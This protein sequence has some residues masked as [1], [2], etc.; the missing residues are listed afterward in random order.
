MTLG[1]KSELNFQL[2]NYNNNYSYAKHYDCAKLQNVPI[3]LKNDW[4][5]NQGMLDKK[6]GDHKQNL[7]TCFVKK[8]K[9]NLTYK[10]HILKEFGT[11]QAV[12]CHK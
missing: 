10:M 6:L 1:L 8:L 3:D 4:S 12:S 5:R 2:E 11:C 9:S 7:L